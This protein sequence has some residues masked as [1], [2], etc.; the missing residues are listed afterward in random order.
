MVDGDEIE[1]TGRGVYGGYLDFDFLSEFVGAPVGEFAAGFDSGGA[2]FFGFAFFCFFG[3]AGD[4]FGADESFD[5]EAFE[6]DEDAEV[7]DG[8]DDGVGLFPDAVGEH[9]QEFGVAEVVFGVFGVFFGL[10]A[11]LA[12]GGELF[13]VGELIGG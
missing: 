12:E 6:L 1:G 9:L 11:V 4:V 2:V 7:G 8:G 10:G 13:E 5:E 3:W